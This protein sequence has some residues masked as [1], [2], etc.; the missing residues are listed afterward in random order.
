ME[1][2]CFKFVKLNKNIDQGHKHITSAIKSLTGG[3]KMGLN[4]NRFLSTP[5]PEISWISCM[6]I[7]HFQEIPSLPFPD[8]KIKPYGAWKK[9]SGQNK[10]LSYPSL[11]I[12]PK[13]RKFSDSVRTHWNLEQFLYP[14][15]GPQMTFWS[16]MV[17]GEPLFHQDEPIIYPISPI[18]KCGPQRL[19]ASHPQL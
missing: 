14:N 10:W 17:T 1:R 4:L 16:F 18:L 13:N 15:S 6:N 11:R 9:C 2:N 19:Q 7:G 3:G 12:P 8:W 5:I